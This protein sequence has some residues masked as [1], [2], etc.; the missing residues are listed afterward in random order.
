MAPVAYTVGVPHGNPATIGDAILAVLEVAV[1]VGIED[2]LS[3]HVTI[4]ELCIGAPVLPAT[5][6][7]CPDIRIAIARATT[8]AVRLKH[9]V[10]C[11]GTLKTRVNPHRERTGWLLLKPVCIHDNVDTLTVFTGSLRN[12]LFANDTAIL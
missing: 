2:F 5:I 3:C 10:A 12:T 4:R 8:I 11:S 9:P 6:V 1:H 7:N